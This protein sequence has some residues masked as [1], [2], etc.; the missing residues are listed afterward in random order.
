MVSTPFFKNAVSKDYKK[1]NRR[2]RI[3]FGAQFV[4]YTDNF[5]GKQF[6]CLGFF[7]GFYLLA[8]PETINH[9]KH[10]KPTAAVAFF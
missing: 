2:R 6:H 9:L 5:S 4:I 1:K 8:L 10:S 7:R 3:I